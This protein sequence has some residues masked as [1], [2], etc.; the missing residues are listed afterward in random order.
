[1]WARKKCWLTAGSWKLSCGST[2][3]MM[4]S[5]PASVGNAGGEGDLDQE[6]R[7]VQCR[8]GDGGAGRLVGRKELRVL[9]VVS[10]EIL[11]AGQVRGRG[12]HVVER[13]PG[14]L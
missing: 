13:G 9:L 10:G 3:D 6:L 7:R 8:H 12:Q 1:M 11:N 2:T 5:S 14:R 4:V